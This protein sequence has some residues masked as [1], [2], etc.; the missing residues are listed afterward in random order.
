MIFKN[1]IVFLYWWPKA[2][3]NLFKWDQSHPLFTCALNYIDN[4]VCHLYCIS[5]QVLFFFLDRSEISWFFYSKSTCILRFYKT[6]IRL[7]GWMKESRSSHSNSFLHRLTCKQRMNC[8]IIEFN[9][10]CSYTLTF[11]KRISML[12]KKMKT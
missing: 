1:K 11:V 2:I 6:L 9:S 8:F 3:P 4:I 5:T 10:F 7:W 12:L